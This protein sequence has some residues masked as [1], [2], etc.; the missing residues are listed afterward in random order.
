MGLRVD[1][2]GGRIC[3]QVVTDRMAPIFKSDSRRLRRHRWLSSDET[4]ERRGRVSA[5]GLKQ[6]P[7]TRRRKDA[8]TT[9]L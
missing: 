1:Y 9:P 6:D 2:R 3:L 5:Q 8:D 7:S 4:T